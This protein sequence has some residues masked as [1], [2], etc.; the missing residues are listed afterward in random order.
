M[1]HSFRKFF[2]HKLWQ[3]GL[4]IAV[5][6]SAL[7]LTFPA[8][9]LLRF[10]S[11]GRDVAELQ[12][13]L[14]IPDDGIFGSDTEAAVLDFQRRNGLEEDGIAGAETLRAL[15][16]EYLIERGELASN[17]GALPTG[18]PY[19]VAIPG[20]DPAVLERTQRFVAG[21]ISD[22]NSE[23]GSFINAGE[24]FQRDTAESV[25]R[26]LRDAGLPA[27]VEFIP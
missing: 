15:D 18:G 14:G 23:R 19:V 3:V 13:A 8:L 17:P 16:L 7:G 20:D 6:F 12:E 27:R 26:E 21:A 10:G 25:S 24:Y 9:A 22:E 5:T 1:S 11:E 4:A 2:P